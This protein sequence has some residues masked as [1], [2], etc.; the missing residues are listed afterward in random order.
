MDVFRFEDLLDCFWTEHV[1]TKDIQPG[2]LVRTESNDWVHVFRTYV[3]EGMKRQA[4]CFAL[5]SFDDGIFYVA[6]D[7][8]LERVKRSAYSSVRVLRLLEFAKVV[9]RLEAEYED[10]AAVG[11]GE[12]DPSLRVEFL[13]KLN[14]AIRSFRRATREERETARTQQKPGEVGSSGA[15]T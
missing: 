3:D 5:E 1:H 10:S 7:E 2:D 13:R 14:E 6:P 8:P 4:S 9:R 12:A 15:A 11:D